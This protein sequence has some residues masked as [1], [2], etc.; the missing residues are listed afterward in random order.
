M[1]CSQMHAMPGTQKRPLR[2][3]ILQCSYHVSYSL[4]V[5]GA[6]HWQ[7]EKQL[8]LPGLV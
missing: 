5:S 7:I 4:P 2:F 3:D 1:P 6:V 8:L